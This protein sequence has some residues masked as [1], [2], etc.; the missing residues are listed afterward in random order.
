MAV[1]ALVPLIVTA[2]ELKEQLGV[3]V[4]P[5]MVHE[6]LT[7]PEKPLAGVTVTVDVDVCPAE[8]ETGVSAAAVSV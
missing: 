1:A 5:L 2:G 7:L 4:P 6:R 8:T 3:G